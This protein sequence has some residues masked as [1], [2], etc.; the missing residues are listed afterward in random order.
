MMRPTPVAVARVA[1]WLNGLGDRGMALA[2]VSALAL[3][4]AEPAL[5]VTERLH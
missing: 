4:P 2:P 3:A 5:K 1:A